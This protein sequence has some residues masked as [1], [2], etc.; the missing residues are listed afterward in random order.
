MKKFFSGNAKIPSLAAAIICLAAALFLNP[1][2]DEPVSENN[3]IEAQIQYSF[4]SEELLKSHFEKHGIEMGFENEEDYL[5]AANQVINNPSSLHKLEAEDGDD[6][7][8]L[9]DS[10]EFV[11]VSTDGYIRTYFYPG[12]GIDYYNRQ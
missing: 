12:S 10:N 9:E 2:K 8:Y 6:V 1:V 4:R 11:I 7:Y 3:A 5:K